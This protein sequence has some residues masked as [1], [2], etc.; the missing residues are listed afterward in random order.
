MWGLVVE[1]LGVKDFQRLAN[2]AVLLI[3]TGVLGTWNPETPVRNAQTYLIHPLV[4][5]KS[6]GNEAV[7]AVTFEEEMQPLSSIVVWFDL[8]IYA[9]RE[10]ALFFFLKPASW[11]CR[12]RSTS[13]PDFWNSIAGSAVLCNVTYTSG[14]SMYCAWY[15]ICV[16]SKELAA[17]VTMC[18]GCFRSRSTFK[19]YL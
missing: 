14:W 7:L 6:Q 4:V 18:P 15:Y 12:T 19:I 13:S 10:R 1:L 11:K 8:Q 9:S 3:Q 17:P 2:W 5:W 16:K